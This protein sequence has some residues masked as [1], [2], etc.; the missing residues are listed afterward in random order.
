MPRLLTTNLTILTILFIL[1]L[2]SCK[3]KT[4][5]ESV[6]SPFPIAESNETYEQILEKNQD[7][8]V[9]ND[10][11]FL[12]FQI[13]MN[14]EQLDRHLLTLTES[15]KVVRVN[16]KLYA[17]IPCDEHNEMDKD[18][19]NQLIGELFFHFTESSGLNAIY[20][21]YYGPRFYI[22]PISQRVEDISQLE[23]PLYQKYVELMGGD[24]AVKAASERAKTPEDNSGLI[25]WLLKNNLRDPYEKRYGGGRTRKGKENYDSRFWMTG[26]RVIEL[27]LRKDET[28]IA[29]E[30][31]ERVM[32]ASKDEFSGLVFLG[33]AFYS[34][35]KYRVQLIQ[36]SN[37]TANSLRGYMDSLYRQ[38][39]QDSEREK[40]QRAKDAGF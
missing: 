11:I 16:N 4:E 21:A 2:V 25:Y 33:D 31:L 23:N 18:N 26:G 35:V 29:R 15:G 9:T 19:T 38:Q 12:G 34:T 30:Y 13:G 6:T 3:S 32:P 1:T 5:P 36:V 24:S 17:L 14:K 7:Y 28:E 39:Q 8:A 37:E 27:N 22:K 40:F 10:T 20:V